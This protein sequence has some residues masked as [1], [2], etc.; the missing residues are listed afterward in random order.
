MGWDKKVTEYMT[1]NYCRSGWNEN[2]R[3]LLK[4]IIETLMRREFK[5]LDVGCG[6]GMYYRVLSKDNPDIDYTGIDYSKDMIDKCKKLFPRDK[7]PNTKFLVG[8]IFNLNLSETYDIVICSEVLSHLPTYMRPLQE[9]FK[10][11]SGYLIIKTITRNDRT[12]LESN[13]QWGNKF[14]RHEI[15]KKEFTLVVNSMNPKNFFSI[16]IHNKKG[17]FLKRRKV[18]H[19]VFIIH[20][21]PD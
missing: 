8:D 19:T 12:K 1:E 15:N 11:T 21:E 2:D 18:Q 16:D 5:I 7:Y 4:D 3:K 14:L 9:L 17:R 6:T 20:F 13:V 10:V